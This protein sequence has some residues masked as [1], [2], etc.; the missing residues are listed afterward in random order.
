M[1]LEINSGTIFLNGITLAGVLGGLASTHE[2]GQGSIPVR[3]HV[4]VSA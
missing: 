3:A 2:P 1:S 4:Q